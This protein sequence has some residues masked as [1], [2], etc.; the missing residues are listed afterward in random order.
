MLSP[1]SPDRC[2]PVYAFVS[3]ISS[4]SP[5]V[6]PAV[7]LQFL[8]LS[9]LQLLPAARLELLERPS[10]IAQRSK[11]PLSPWRELA[12][13]LYSRIFFLFCSLWKAISTVSLA[14]LLLARSSSLFVLLLW[15]YTE[16]EHGFLV[17]KGSKK[18]ILP[19]RWLCAQIAEFFARLN[20]VS[21][22]CSSAN[23]PERFAAI[24]WTLASSDLWRVGGFQPFKTVFR[25]SRKD[26]RSFPFFVIV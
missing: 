18:A 2:I 16:C 5:P 10:Y 15:V 22:S 4:G 6:S 7:P 19:F 13:A 21:K 8:Q 26:I 25:S 9:S 23:R 11:A 24:Q 1:L 12:A 14:D 17:Q 3:L 20:S